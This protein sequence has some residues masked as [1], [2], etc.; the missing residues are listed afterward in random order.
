MRLLRVMRSISWRRT[1]M[2]HRDPRGRGSGGM[3]IGVRSLRSRSLECVEDGLRVPGDLDRTPRLADD[4]VR[5][6]EEGAALDAE[7]LAPVHVLFLDHAEGVAQR[8]VAV[9]GELEPKAL[10]RAEVLVRFQR[11]ARYADD[12]GAE[13]AE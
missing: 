4:A 5:V 3:K 10:L 13:P 1:A 8:F 11:I 7:H 2:D 12:I 6:D 9:A